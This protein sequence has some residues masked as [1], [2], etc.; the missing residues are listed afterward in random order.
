MKTKQGRGRPKQ[1]D[2]AT[3]RQAVLN[4]F[5]D[6][7]YAGASLSELSEAAGVSRPSLY[8]LFG[9]KHAMYLASLNAVEAQ[10]NAALTALLAGAAPIADE[11]TDFFDAAIT[12]YLSG[13]APRGCMIM[14]TA[15]VEA[16]SDAAIRDQ[17]ATVI[18]QIDG[19]FERRFECAQSCGEILPS[20]SAKQLAHIAT[21]TLQS[22]ALRARAGTKE[23]MLRSMA[24]ETIHFLT[25]IDSAG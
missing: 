13:S 5:W 24:R 10:L 11:L 14:C 9:D 7:G 4:Q 25:K 3:V 8:E 1:V 6:K 12:L 19:A 18:D 21:A 23:T 22:I 17:L 16:S 15:P 2:E 20:A